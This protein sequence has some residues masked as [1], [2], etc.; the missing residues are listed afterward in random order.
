MKSEPHGTLNIDTANARRLGL[1]NL[2]PVQLQIISAMV[3]AK[4]VTSTEAAMAC[5]GIPIVQRSSTVVYI[6]SKPPNMRTTYITRSRILSIHSTVT[7]T[8]RHPD[9]EHL[10]FKYYFK[11]YELVKDRYISN[12]RTYIGVDSIGNYLYETQKWSDSLNT[13]R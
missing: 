9:F 7:Y 8:H 6:D 10:P 12:L 3:T 5:L 2:H 13:I 4:P 11:K 1:D